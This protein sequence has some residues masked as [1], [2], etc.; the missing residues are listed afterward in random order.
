[1]DPMKQPVTRAE[2]ARA[3][4]GVREMAVH[5]DDL[6]KALRLVTAR[7]AQMEQLIQDQAKQL[8]ELDPRKVD[9]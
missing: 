9:A 4:A 3:W 6:K 1:M 5:V 2:F 8:D 7:M